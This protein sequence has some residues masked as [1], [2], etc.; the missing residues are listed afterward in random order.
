MAVRT[1]K[2]ACAC[3]IAGGRIAPDGTV[4][5]VSQQGELRIRNSCSHLT[6]IEHQELSR[7]HG[8]IGLGPIGFDSHRVDNQVAVIRTTVEAGA[9]EEKRI[10]RTADGVGVLIVDV[11]FGE[12]LKNSLSGHLTPPA[13]STWAVQKQGRRMGCAPRSCFQWTPGRPQPGRTARRSLTF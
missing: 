10:L 1:V 7:L 11:D 6:G 12:L 9:V 2:R 5:G 3:E 8:E 13:A 4:R